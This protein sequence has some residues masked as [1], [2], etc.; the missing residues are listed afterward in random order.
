M[1]QKAL[2]TPLLCQFIHL[3]RLSISTPEVLWDFV[4]VYHFDGQGCKNSVD[5]VM[6][7]WIFFKKWYCCSIASN[8]QK[9]N[10]NNLINRTNLQTFYPENFRYRLKWIDFDLLLR[11]KTLNGLGPSYI[12]N[13]LFQRLPEEH[14]G[15]R[16]VWKV[17][18]KQSCKSLFLIII[19]NI[20]CM[21]EKG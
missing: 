11:C 1:L 9:L 17:L 7:I 5:C 21:C 13:S 12:V 8:F 2:V 18:C 6:L 20:D 16:L 4:L 14:C 10:N 15:H 19:I 3:S